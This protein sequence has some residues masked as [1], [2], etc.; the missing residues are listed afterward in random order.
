MLIKEW[1]IWSKELSWFLTKLLV[2]QSINYGRD[3]YTAHKLMAWLRSNQWL[4]KTF[5][6]L[7]IFTWNCKMIIPQNCLWILRFWINKFENVKYVVYIYISK[8]NY[9]TF[10]S[11]TIMYF[12]W[13]STLLTYLKIC[14]IQAQFVLIKYYSIFSIIHHVA[15]IEGKQTFWIIQ[16][17]TFIEERYFVIQLTY[18]LKKLILKFDFN[19][20]ASAY[21]H[22]YCTLMVYFNEF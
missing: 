8:L 11:D 4:K 5:L 6:S 20:F 14:I 12:F 21:T 19:R 13:K 17:T 10:Y 22:V 3:I 1:E 15:M 7:W 18:I 2:G 16:G 9:F